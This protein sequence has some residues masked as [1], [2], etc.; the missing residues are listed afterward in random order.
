MPLQRRQIRPAPTDSPVIL[1]II[2][3]LS[4]DEPDISVDTYTTTAIGFCS[5]DPIGF[6]GS[7]WNLY[8]YV[9]S[10][11]LNSTDP[12]GLMCD[13]V[14]N[15]ARKCLELATFAAQLEC[16]Q[17]FIVANS[18][19]RA[20]YN[21]VQQLHHLFTAGHQNAMQLSRMLGSPS[22]AYRAVM[23]MTKQSTRA[24]RFKSVWFQS[25]IR[26]EYYR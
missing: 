17:P 2:S 1:A 7:E 26:N 12:T 9:E 15:A 22:A 14:T 8:E 3:T 24:R 4:I 10:N 6:E 13:S 19:A 16:L 23:R 20:M 21:N 11:P 18:A 25:T 5:R